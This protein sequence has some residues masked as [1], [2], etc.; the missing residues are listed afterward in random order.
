MSK[1]A[2]SSS[3]TTSMRLYTSALPTVS[4]YAEYAD[5]LYILPYDGIRLPYNRHALFKHRSQL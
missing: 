1:V 5:K 2:C 4:Y 3:P